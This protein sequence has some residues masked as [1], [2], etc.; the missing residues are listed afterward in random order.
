MVPGI[1]S[2]ISLLNS[3]LKEVMVFP[4]FLKFMKFSLRNIWLFKWG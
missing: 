4:L 2:I 1:E 3:C